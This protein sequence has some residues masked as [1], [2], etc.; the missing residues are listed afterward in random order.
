MNTKHG[1]SAIYLEKPLYDDD[2]EE[3]DW[4]NITIHINEIN[5]PDAEIGITDPTYRL[6]KEDVEKEVTKLT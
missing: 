5:E 6:N 1:E 3:E 4:D 2:L